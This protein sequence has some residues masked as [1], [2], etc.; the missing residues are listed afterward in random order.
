M[1][2]IDTHNHLYADAFDSDRMDVLQKAIDEGVEQILLPNIDLESI[3][4]MLDLKETNP[5]V[6]MPMMGLHPC[7]VKEDYQTVLADMKRKLDEFPFIAVGE[8]GI[9]LYWDKTFQQ[10]Q[11]EAFKTQIHWAKEKGLPI[12]IHCREAF[13]EIIAVLDEEND[14]R[15]RGVFHCFSG[16]L[17]Q[18]NQVLAYG[19]F[20]LGIGGVLTF[21]N[22]G[23][24]QVIEQ[25]DLE[26]L[27]LETDA[28]YLAPAPFRG[29]RNEPAYLLRVAEKLAEIKQVPLTKV[30]EI[31]TQNAE[32]LFK[33]KE[34]GAV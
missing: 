24:D 20:K 27:I 1:R 10:E 3:A 31:T 23:L 5:G 21:K 12:A 28:P 19:G 25:V 2:L 15:L 11:V 17:E 9:D 13:D 29:K 7:S 16:S 18:A 33:I 30:A 6:C 22:A 32:E 14:D 26:H 34:Y 4:G 8:I